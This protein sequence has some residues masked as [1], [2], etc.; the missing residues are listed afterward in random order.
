MFAFF[1]HDGSGTIDLGEMLTAFRAAERAGSPPAGGGTRARADAA[2][3]SDE[4]EYETDSDEELAALASQ[5]SWMAAPSPKEKQRK[6]RRKKRKISLILQRRQM[7]QGRQMRLRQ[8]RK[9]RQMRQM[10]Q[11]S[12][13]RQKRQMGQ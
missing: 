9:M 8:Q 1:D 2:G 7:D 5:P 13:S 10:R 12:Q 4:S 6:K 3:R 11:M